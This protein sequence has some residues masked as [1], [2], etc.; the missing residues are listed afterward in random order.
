MGYGGA[1]LE[2]FSAVLITREPP[3]IWL[4]SEISYAS[5]KD[6]CQAFVAKVAR[7][8]EAIYPWSAV[9]IMLA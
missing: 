5:Q 8:L 1:R 9:T 4:P 6:L 2:D 3:Q 7:L